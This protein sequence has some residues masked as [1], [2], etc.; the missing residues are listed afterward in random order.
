MPVPY[1]EFAAWTLFDLAI[2][3]RLD[4]RITYSGNHVSAQ[5]LL[6]VRFAGETREQFAA[7]T[8]EFLKSLPRHSD[9][10]ERLALAFEAFRRDGEK[11]Y[12]AAVLVSE[13]LQVAPAQ[14]RTEYER[15]GIGYAYKP[16]DSVLGTTR[17]GRREK[18][19]R[20]GISREERQVESIRAQATRFIH[21]HK[22]FEKLFLD[23]LGAFKWTFRRDAEWYAQAENTCLARVAAFEELREPF[24]WWSAMP[25]PA[26]AYLYHEQRK[27]ADAVAYY[28]KAIAAARR[29][30]MHPD[31]RAFV[32]HWMRLG[33]KLGLGSAKV[34]RMPAFDV[35]RLP[36]DQW[37]LS[38]NRLPP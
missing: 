34:V 12:I 1:R 14:K 2:R 37:A 8:N 26:A 16:I 38:P 31:L 33:V 27:F 29:A 15:R 17:R 5:F 13:I 11:T 25:L 18:R 35:R 22:N 23:R 20:R 21:S 19:K 9:L 10:S 4:D 3:E 7:R 32:I 36:P 6:P 30:I 28:R 24:E